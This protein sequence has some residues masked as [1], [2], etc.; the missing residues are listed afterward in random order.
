MDDRRQTGPQRLHLWVAALFALVAALVGIGALSAA[1]LNQA[2]GDEDARLR[3]GQLYEQSNDTLLA[4]SALYDAL[5]DAERGQRGYALTLNPVFL[6]PYNQNVSEVGARL[7]RLAALVADDEGLSPKII[8]LRTISNLKLDEMEEVITTI[9][10]GRVDEARAYISSGYGRRLMEQIG[11]LIVELQE[12]EAAQVEARR[13][14]ALG[15]AEDSAASISRLAQFGIALL[16]SAILAVVLIALL[17]ARTYRAAMR[18]EMI[19]LENEQL[20]RAVADRTAALTR[21]NERLI[22]EADSRESAETRL[23]QAQR[24]EAVGQLTGGI[25]HDF[26]N[27]LSVVIGN[28]DLLKRRID[29]EPKVLRLIDNALEGADR[30][31]TLT[32]RLLAF[33]RQQSLKP[34]VTDVNAL[35]TD[36]EDFLRRTLTETVRLDFALGED[37]PDVFVDAAEL[38]NVILNLGANARDAMPKGGTLSISTSAETLA[39]ETEMH[40]QTLFPGQYAVIEIA[41]TGEGMPEEVLAKVYEPFFTTKPVGKGTGLGLS[42]VQ[43]FVIQSGGSIDIESAPGEGT[44]IR[45]LLPEGEQR[46]DVA[47]MLASPD[48]DELPT[49]KPGEA[50]LV[51]EDQEQLRLLTTDVLRDLGYRVEE[52]ESGAEALARLSAGGDETLLF[53]DIVMPDQSG[54]ELARAVRAERPGIKLL[55]TSGYTQAVGVDAA[56]LDPPADLLRKPYTV[57]Q[58]ARAVRRAIDS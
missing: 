37:V 22:A 10:E 52:A 39:D 21:A 30:A 12:A 56:T 3:A 2:V 9:D 43:G 16:A 54:D 42:Q 26:N 6:D 57:D 35:V 31:A 49:A 4:A 48:Q 5:Q 34:A 38:E 13:R 44:T 19:E 46:E 58:L 23:R 20:E 45:I 27:M 29:A 17:L 14:A 25:A 1:A 53:T 47:G 55:Y 24:L 11:N 50:V 8:S 32:S 28:L 36:M 33:S 41:D 7:D 18:E 15:S 40:G 51:V